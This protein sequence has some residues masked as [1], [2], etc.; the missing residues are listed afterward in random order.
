[1]YKGTAAFRHQL[2]LRDKTISSLIP[3]DTNIKMIKYAVQKII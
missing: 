1:M 2:D 3:F